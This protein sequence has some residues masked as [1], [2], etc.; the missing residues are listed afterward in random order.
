MGKIIRIVL[1]AVVI[2]GGVYAYLDEESI[3]KNNQAVSSFDSGDTSDEVVKQLQEAAE[4]SATKETKITAL[5]NLAYLYESREEEELAR[6]TFE[7]AL[8]E[9]KQDSLDYHLIK[10][11]IAY[12]DNDF[13]QA[14]E[15]F[16][17]AH[18]IN[19]NDFQVNNTLALFYID[20]E[21]ES[22]EVVNYP[23]ALEHAREA[24]EKSDSDM[25]NTAGTNLAIAHYFNDNFDKTVE[26]LKDRDFDKDPSLALWV[27]LAY[28]GEEDQGNARLYLKEAKQRG[29]DIGPD[30]EAYL[31]Q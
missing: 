6:Q 26:L 7:K 15:H 18:Q 21:N 19:P 25:K 2:I 8:R 30:L 20:L 13:S 9:A 23:K 4:K 14:G 27:G 31:Q 12:L 10:G 29:V 17:K 22:P 5:K 16:R 24:Y 1:I 3:D 28:L 11:E